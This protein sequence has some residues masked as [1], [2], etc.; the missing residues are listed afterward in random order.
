VEG[1]VSGIGQGGQVQSCQ[2]SL[3]EGAASCLGWLDVLRRWERGTSCV[4]EGA[5]L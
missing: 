3:S 5:I 1:S 4:G 2:G